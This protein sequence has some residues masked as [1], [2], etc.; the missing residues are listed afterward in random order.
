[1]LIQQ[2]N[3]TDAER[4]QLIVKNVDGGGSITTGYPVALCIAA[5]STD[6]VSAVRGVVALN[7]AFAGVAAQD[8][9]INSYGLVTAWGYCGSILLSQSVGSFT[10][11][12]GDQLLL[13][14]ANAGF[15]SVITPEAS[16]TQYYK[17]VI[18]G[19]MCQATI[20][21]PLPYA[22]GIVRAL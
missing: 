20:S 5:A 19:G 12:A 17:Y 18:A 1:M 14:A 3:R 13:G 22:Y 10:V 9:A 4:V 7:K 11:T 21:N 8:I 15:T 16:S 6:G 2:L